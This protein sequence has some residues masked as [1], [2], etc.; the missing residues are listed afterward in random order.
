MAG[1]L[2]FNGGV[3]RNGSRDVPTAYT[4]NAMG[5]KATQNYFLSK[6]AQ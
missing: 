5:K 4:A 1:D 3:K 2:F 6:F